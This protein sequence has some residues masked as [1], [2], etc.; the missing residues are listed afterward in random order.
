MGG[1]QVCQKWLKD[2][3]GRQLTE[4]EIEHYQKNRGC[5]E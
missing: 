1:Y 5:V 4:E 3:K 2:R